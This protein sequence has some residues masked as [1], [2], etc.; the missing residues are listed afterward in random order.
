MKDLTHLTFSVTKR[1]R[2]DSC[3]DFRGEETKVTQLAKVSVGTEAQAVDPTAC[4][5]GGSG[6]SRA[7]S[8]EI[9][10]WMRMC[11]FAHLFFQDGQQEEAGGWSI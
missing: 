7:N 5:P 11:S 9:V 10:T 1:G 2:S 8:G 6:D 4:V 3:P